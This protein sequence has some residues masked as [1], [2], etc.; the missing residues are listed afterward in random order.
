MG[1]GRVSRNTRGR[2][3]SCQDTPLPLH[4]YTSAARVQRCPSSSSGAAYARVR[5]QTVRALVAGQPQVAQAGP[6]VLGEQHLWQQ[7]WGV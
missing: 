4:L 2:V 5:P 7:E 1:W 3:T 6:Q